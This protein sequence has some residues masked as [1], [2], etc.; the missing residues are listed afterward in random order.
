M[1]IDQ[2]RPEA[3]QGR[4]SSSL[5][6]LGSEVAAAVSTPLR[7][8]S[9]YGKWALI[10][11][12]FIFLALLVVFPLINILVQAFA[13]GWG[14]FMAGITTPEA[15]HA[16]WM[17]VLITLWVVPLNTVFGVLT[18]WLLA[19]YRFPGRLLILGLLDLPIA[20][21]PVV[22]GMLVMLTYSPTIGLVGPFFRS[23]GIQIVFAWPSMVLV[24]LFITFPF[25]VREVLPALQEH[26][27]SAEEAAYT[28]GASPWQ[29][30]WR[31][32]LPNIRWA[33]MYGIIL[34]TARA[35]GEF[36]AI[37]VVSGKVIRQ[38]NT[39][40]L[41][42]QRVYGEFDTVAAFGASLL[43]SMIAVVTLVV[44]LGLKEKRE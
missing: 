18:A 29:A 26:G 10:S 28:L 41:H 31:V 7:P 24:T 25:V 3:N 13:A 32:T 17:T 23:Q 30:F 36:G 16:I 15:R 19:R 9:P 33:I 34:C 8:P 4:D 11:L 40:T 37:S 38:T 27:H 21:S 2:E 43:L 22:V 1:T 12:G 44:Q 5:P 35:I 14:A 39:L 6:P 20:I 42:V